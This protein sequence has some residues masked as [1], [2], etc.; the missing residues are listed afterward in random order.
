MAIDRRRDATPPNVT[1][2]R[3]PLHTLSDLPQYLDRQRDDL[4]NQLQTLALLVPQVAESEPKQ[5]VHGM[6]R[7]ARY[8]WTPTGQI[9]A[10]VWWDASSETW[11]P[12][13][14]GSGDASS[15]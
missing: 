14:D 15:M 13:R 7:L 12:V 9:S 8:P 11:L 1:L 4:L 5:R 10:W 6:M 2:D 3:P